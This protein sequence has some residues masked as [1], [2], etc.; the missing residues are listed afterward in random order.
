[1]N[2]GSWRW[3]AFKLFFSQFVMARSGR[4]PERFLCSRADI[5]GLFSVRHG[6]RDYPPNNPF[7]QWILT[8]Q[9]MDL[10][11]PV[12]QFG[13]PKLLAERTERVRLVCADLESF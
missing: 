13:E 2:A 9:Y 6:L 3:Q 8:G 12:S 4:S 10:S 5:A 7:I 11:P 1:M